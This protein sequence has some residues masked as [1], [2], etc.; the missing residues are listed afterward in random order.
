MKVSGKRLELSA[1]HSVPKDGPHSLSDIREMGIKLAEGK[2]LPGQI[3]G[4]GTNCLN[5]FQNSNAGIHHLY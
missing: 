2:I 3:A 5:D 1:H 4:V